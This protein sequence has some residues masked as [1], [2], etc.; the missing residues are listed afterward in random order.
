MLGTNAGQADLIGYLKA[1]NWYVIG[2]SGRSGEPGQVLCD[3]FVQ[4]D[5]RDVDALQQLVS[6]HGI[7]L[8]Y[9]VSSDLAMKSVV[10]LSE[11]T[12][13]PHFF[14]NDFIALLDN[15]AD[16][17]AFLDRNDLSPV[18]YAEVS[19]VD[20]AA[21]WSRFPCVVKPTD[22]QGQRG[23]Q[24]VEDRGALDEAVEAAIASSPTNKAIVEDYLEGVEMSCNVVLSEGRAIVKIVSERLVHDLD[25][26]GIPKGHLVPPMAVSAADQAR[27]IELVDKVVAAF[28]QSEGVLYFQMIN[29]SDGP[30]IV[31]IAPRLD[32]CHMWRIILAAT[33]VDIIDLAVHGLLGETEANPVEPVVHSGDFELMFQQMA[34]GNP[35][36]PAE[37]PAPTD[38]IYHEHRY[39]AGETVRPINGTLEVV[40]YYVRKTS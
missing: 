31:E 30:R 4:I 27:A 39:A 37:F 20:E 5:I 32:G 34:P 28:G 23:V 17:R 9:S 8:I 36:D 29:T 10:A 26:I 13:L 2:C 12:G 19:T 6:R 14:D 15:K 38:S 1:N 16:L 11:R 35:F 24:R 22:A 25:Q 21:D 3:L 18:P 40:G 33:G 7:D